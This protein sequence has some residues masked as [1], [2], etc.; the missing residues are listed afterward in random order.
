[1]GQSKMFKK[2]ALQISFGLLFA[3]IVGAVILSISL[4]LAFKLTD[5]GRT[6]SDVKT[7]KELDVLLNLFETGFEDAVSVPIHLPT[8][9]RI[10]NSCS[11]SGNFGKQSISTSQES[12]GRFSDGSVKAESRNR[13]I[14]SD[15]IVEGKKFFIFSKPFEFPFKVSDLIYLISSERTYCF[16]NPDQHIEDEILKL[17]Q[18]NLLVKN[19]TNCKGDVIKVC[20]SGRSDCD[21]KVIYNLGSGNVRKDG[22]T[23]HF[24]TDAL[25]YAAIFSDNETY[26]CQLK[27]LMKKTGHLSRIY[28][29]K[30][31]L[32]Q[33]KKC[34]TNLNPQLLTLNNFADGFADSSD[35]RGVKTNVDEIGRKNERNLC[36]LW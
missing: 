1:M 29:E 19:A 34:T 17:K 16:V 35:L 15:E 7:A 2:G 12:F 24:E 36:K 5:T 9:T 31:H 18:K 28:R 14:F 4:Y 25:M 6:G 3:I 21:I 27:R 13:Y 26:E 22:D 23:F 30:A 11:A 10:Y 32:V 33:I 8:N 20:F